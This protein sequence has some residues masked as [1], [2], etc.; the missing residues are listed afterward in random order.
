[1]PSDFE[2][3]LMAQ[4]KRLCDTLDKRTGLYTTLDRYYDGNHPLPPAV[5]DDANV[6]RAY[7]TLMGMSSGNWPKLI[8]D[9]VEERLEVQG[10]RFGDKAADDE[11][12]G[13]WQEN[14][15]DADSSMLH[16]S[17]LTDGR[18]YAIVWG[19]GKADPDP[20]IILEHASMCAIEYAP[21]GSQRKRL[22]AIRRWRE[23]DDWFVNLYRPEAIYKFKAQHSGPNSPAD[24]ERRDVVGEEWPLK[25]PLGVVPVVEFTVN[26][27]LR[28]GTPFGAARGEFEPHL[29]HVD[30][31]NYIVFS[32]LVAL[33]WSGFPLRALIGDPILYDEGGY[34]IAPF[35]AV[36]SQ[37]IQV[38]NPDG[39]IVQTPGADMSNFSPEMHIKHLAA[40]T[41]TPAHYLLAELVN[42]SADAIRAGEAALISKTKRHMRPLG[43]SWEEVMRLALM[44]KNPSDER[45]KDPEG[46]VIW[47]DPE[48]RSMAERADAA[49]KLQDVLPWQAICE[50]YLGMTPQEIGRIESQRIADGLGQLVQQ[51][52]RTT[53]TIP[54]G[55]PGVAEPTPPAAP[56]APETGKSGATA[57]PPGK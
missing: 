33:T 18:A 44:V 8:V 27:T 39:K 26:R 51:P 36:A 45:A 15:L 20:E 40:L 17:T 52:I 21:G 25:N 14:G 22:A 19:D 1:M 6:K 47:A 48:S 32:G 57:V 10:M 49:V 16:Q 43:E 28:P 9:S 54:P 24:W 3:E 55:T 37:V 2:N 42:L 41:K 12:W 7:R 11:V 35:K 30:R 50:R 5:Q 4:T 46:E 53:L 13:M 31:I 56:A 29:R 34:P 38:E 23:G